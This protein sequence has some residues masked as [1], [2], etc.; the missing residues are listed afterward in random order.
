MLATALAIVAVP[1]GASHTAE[2][3]LKVP[4]FQILALNTRI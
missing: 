3:T 2:Y 4:L 1:K